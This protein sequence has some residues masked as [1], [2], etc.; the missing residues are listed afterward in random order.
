MLME[1]SQ[2][3]DSIGTEAVKVTTN[4]TTA[5]PDRA[6]QVGKERHTSYHS[7]VENEH[8]GITTG[9]IHR[10]DVKELHHKYDTAK[11]AELGH[12]AC[13]SVVAVRRR[14]TGDVF[15]MKTVSLAMVGAQNFDELRME[16]DVQ[17]KLDHPN[18]ARI[19]E[20]FEDARHGVMHIVME[21]CSGGSLV[22]RM[23]NHRYGY[24]ERNAATLIERLLSAVTYCHHHGI[25]HRDI[26]LD[27]I[28]YESDHEGSELKLI[29]FGFATEVKRGSPRRRCLASVTPR[30]LSPPH[31]L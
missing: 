29:D 10:A 23:K 16:I 18:I 13:G 22:S 8:A 14:D 6:K 3:D 24:S 4:A 2:L 11:A 9:L 20:S 27:N 5:S 17:K 19:L 25:V 21:L 7:D 31:A 28:M 30:A 12:G 15:A 1:S 26:K